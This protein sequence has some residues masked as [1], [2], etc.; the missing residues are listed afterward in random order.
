M[1]VTMAIN[2]LSHI[3]KKGLFHIQNTKHEGCEYLLIAP[4]KLT[5]LSNFYALQNAIM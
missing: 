5:E 2:V 1:I 3:H 4:L